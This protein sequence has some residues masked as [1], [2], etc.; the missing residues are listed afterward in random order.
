MDLLIFCSAE[1][2]NRFSG[3]LVEKARALDLESCEKSAHTLFFNIWGFSDYDVLL[4]FQSFWHHGFKLHDYV[5]MKKKVNFPIS[6]RISSCFS[7]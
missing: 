1:K 5:R 7:K 3:G 4:N 2:I 6:E